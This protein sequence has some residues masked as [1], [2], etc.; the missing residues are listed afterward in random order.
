[1]L[2]ESIGNAQADGKGQEEGDEP[3]QE[4]GPVIPSESLYNEVARDHAS[5]D[6][7]RG[8]DQSSYCDGQDGRSPV[9]NGATWF[10]IRICF[11]GGSF[12]NKPIEQR[13]DGREEEQ[14]LVGFQVEVQSSRNGRRQERKSLSVYRA[15]ER[16]I[17][18]RIEDESLRQT[19]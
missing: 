15:A 8:E 1:M 2:A 19:Q 14:R 11:H 12:N 9:R 17:L 5:E 16:L 10:Y 18:V 3:R 4:N 7:N 6:E 13:R